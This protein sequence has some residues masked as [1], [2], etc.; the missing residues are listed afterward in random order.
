MLCKFKTRPVYKEQLMTESV[1]SVLADLHVFVKMRNIVYTR[2]SV[3]QKN[4]DDKSVMP[5]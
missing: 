3:I 1:L 2:T 4:V 5:L